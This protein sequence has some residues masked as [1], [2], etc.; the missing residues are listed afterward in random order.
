MLPRKEAAKGSK[1][2]V[3]RGHLAKEPA[4]LHVSVT[5]EDR[6]GP[7]RLWLGSLERRGGELLSTRRQ[8]FCILVQLH[9][10]ATVTGLVS[11]P[12]SHQ[13]KTSGF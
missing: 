8:E 13:E 1:N 2:R 12:F 7:A 4:D 9:I 3:T 10:F 11:F 6:D 5:P